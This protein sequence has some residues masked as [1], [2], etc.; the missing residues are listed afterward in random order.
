MA[1]LPHLPD[2][3]WQLGTPELLL[4]RQHLRENRICEFYVELKNFLERK[5]Y[6]CAENI[7]DAFALSSS[8]FSAVR[9]SSIFIHALSAGSR[10]CTQATPG[11]VD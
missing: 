1:I 4:H 9:I 8:R 11:P 7:V 10:C 6:L 3:V 2:P 5:I